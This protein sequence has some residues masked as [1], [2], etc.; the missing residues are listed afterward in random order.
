MNSLLLSVIQRS[1]SLEQC[2]GQDF[3]DQGNVLEL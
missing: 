2:S 3:L 1:R